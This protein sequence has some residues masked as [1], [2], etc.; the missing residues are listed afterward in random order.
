MKFR[1]FRRKKDNLYYFQFLSDENQVRLNSPAYA[2]KESCFNGIRQVI[3]SSGSIKNFEKRSDDKGNRFFV[4]TTS[5]GQEIGRSNKYKSEK[6]FDLAIEQ[7][8]AEAPKAATR[9]TEAASTVKTP[10]ET[11]PATDGKGRIYLSQNQPYLCDKLTYDTLQ[12]ESNQKYYFV[13]KDKANN[14]VLI[15][16]DVRGFAAIEDLQ[17]GIKAVMEFAPKKKNYEKR[18]TK[19]GKHYFLLKNDEGKSVAKSSTYYSV[20]RKMDAVVRLVQC[21]G[22]EIKLPKQQLFSDNYLPIT[23][24]AGAE[25][26]HNFE[27]EKS[28]QYYFAFNN[29]AGKTFLRSE[30]YTT[31]NSRNKGIQSV[32]KNGREEKSWT[33]F[34]KNNLHYYTL[35]AGNHQEIARSQYYKDEAAMLQDFNLIKGQNSPIGV[36]AAF[37][38]GALLSAAMIKKQ[39]EEEAAA[40]QKAK[41]EVKQKE[42]E[43]RLAAL[44]AVQ[45]KSEEEAKRNLETMQKRDEA[46][47]KLE[48]AKLAEE[49][50]KKK[51]AEEAAA[52]A[53]TL[54][55]ANKNTSSTSYST[56]N[57]NS[58]RGILRWL[59]PL[60]IALLLISA[61]LLY[62]KACDG[63]GK[64]PIAD[65][66]PPI[67]TTAQETIPAVPYGKGGEALGFL[68]GSMEFLMADHL[69]AFDSEFPRT[70]NAENIA[71]SKNRIRLN[72]KARNQL[73]NLAVLLKEYPNAVIE[74]YGYVV[75]GEKTFYKGNK[76]VSL[77]DARASEVYN[78]MKQ[79]GIEE[80]R[81][82]FYGNGLDDKAGIKIRLVSRGAAK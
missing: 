43:A 37:V 55:A 18:V 9:D 21:T 79:D 12:S 28:G 32:I 6:Q 25:G 3:Q 73:D 22:A 27:D 77:D 41:E 48:K 50:R 65:P 82:E 29:D 42:E 64:D 54:A 15:N 44:A 56:S 40:K 78:Y 7:F 45:L 74:I 20:K 2:D 69:S 60:I 16:A 39:E 61:A 76:E 35:K 62:F 38:G 70:F 72:T 13:F 5:K 19:N 71:F 1:A 17:N 67:D 10:E 58:G 8:I 49:E 36:G 47:K 53:L 66:I 81:L 80:S 24:Y 31:D 30:G 63:C 26:F 23:A 51:N 33:T 59:I 34:F 68:S 11:K 14:P 4:L 52:A 75:K 46:T 57:G